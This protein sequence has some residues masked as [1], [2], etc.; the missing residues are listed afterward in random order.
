MKFVIL[1]SFL[2]S[3]KFLFVCLF[4]FKWFKFEN[5]H[6]M[7]LLLVPWTTACSSDLE[8]AVATTLVVFGTD[9]VQGSSQP[10]SP[11]QW[12]SSWELLYAVLHMH[13]S[14]RS[15]FFKCHFLMS[16]PPQKS[17]M[18]PHCR[19]SNFL[20]WHSKVKVK[21]LVTQSCPTL[22]NSVDC[23]LPGFCLHVILQARILE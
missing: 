6:F 17:F 19:S 21:V 4:Y 5:L 22:C 14:A 1:H 12:L 8:D 23:S 3:L 11:L 13:T 7:K 15:F 18:S 20:N 9:D 2:F 10:T 16:F